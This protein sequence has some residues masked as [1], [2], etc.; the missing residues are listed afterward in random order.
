MSGAVQKTHW[1]KNC[2]E[3]WIWR[4]LFI[5]SRT[6]FRYLWFHRI[7]MIYSLHSISQ[8][9]AETFGFWYLCLFG[10]PWGLKQP[11]IE[12]K[13]AANVIV[14]SCE[15]SYKRLAR[16]QLSRFI[17]I[18]IQAVHPTCDQL[19]CFQFSH[20]IDHIILL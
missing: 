5:D 9:D 6:K 13:D 12:K 11:K 16:V 8:F 15:N 18:Y 10:R 20:I 1:E 19:Y 4:L 7:C 3:F 17:V 2:L 14:E